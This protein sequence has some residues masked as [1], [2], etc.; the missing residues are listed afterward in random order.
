M[1]GRAWRSPHHQPYPSA[2]CG[3]GK[4]GDAL[5]LA[6]E[7]DLRVRNP[8]FLPSHGFGGQQGCSAAGFDR[9]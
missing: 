7:R 6:R 4:S 8:A 1:E 5:A 2:F 3:A 9:A